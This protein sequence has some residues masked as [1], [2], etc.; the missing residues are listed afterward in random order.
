MLALLLKVVLFVLYAAGLGVACYYAYVMRTYAI[1]EY[2]CIIHEA[3]RRS[4]S[5]PMARA[6]CCK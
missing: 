5:S 3:H 6:A 4:A 1:R 2:G